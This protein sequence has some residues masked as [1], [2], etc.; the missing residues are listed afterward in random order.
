MNG[1]KSLKKN[2][3]YNVSYQILLLIVPFITTPYISKTLGVNNI[4]I[5]SY[6]VSLVSYFSILSVFGIHSYASRKIAYNRNEPENYEKIFN[7]VQTTKLISCLIALGAYI[8]FIFFQKVNQQILLILSIHIVGNYFDITWFFQ[9]QENFKTIAIRNFVIKIAS[10]AAIFVF[11]RDSDDLIK[12]ILIIVMSA[13]IGNISL[14]PYLSQYGLRIKLVRPESEI[15]TTS[16]ELFIP[17]IAVQVY[18]M[19]DKSMLGIIQNNMVESGCY[20]QTTKINNLCMTV[21]TSLSAVLAPRMAADFANH[22][23]AAIKR[24]A[25]KTFTIISLLSA[26]MCIGVICISDWFVPWFF[27]VGYEKVVKLLKIYSFVL[28]IIPLSNVAGTVILTPTNQHNKG[29]AAVVAGAVINFILNL[30]LI[31]RI[32]SVGAAIATIVAESV[33]SI[34]HLFFAREYIDLNNIVK[35]EMKF[36]GASLLMGFIISITGWSLLA[37]CNLN[38]IYITVVQ[39]VLGAALYYLLLRYIYKEKIVISTMDSLVRRI[40][41]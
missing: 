23:F 6:T 36:I 21:I 35:N 38:N 18:N 7:E 30:I 11:I 14:W 22:D 16:F 2:Y 13:F 5:Y 28:L 12:Y 26:P 20:E 4:G 3:L 40:K 17:L 33:V 15:I 1:N 27:G 41:K 37:Y 32:A 31:P 9:G 25:D 24:T 8:I 34:I 29:T 39:V 19:L 10:V